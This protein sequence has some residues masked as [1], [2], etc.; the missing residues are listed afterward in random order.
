MDSVDEALAHYGVPGMKWGVRRLRSSSSSSSSRAEASDDYKM[1]RAALSKPSH[2]LSNTE[3]QALIRRMDLEHQYVS[4]LSRA[5][6]KPMTKGG[7]VKKFV[8][9]L[10]L[11]VGKTEVTYLAKQAA[12]TGNKNSPWGKA[13]GLDQKKDKKSK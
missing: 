9:G 7:H 2:A 4:T 8:T 10:L 13:L 6:A 3:M 5:N 1:A 12:R 11:D